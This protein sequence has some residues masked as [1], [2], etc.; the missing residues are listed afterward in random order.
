[1]QRVLVAIALGVA[2]TTPIPAAAQSSTLEFRVSG[3]ST[4]RSWTCTAQ[5]TVTLSAGGPAAP[6]LPNGIRVATIT[7]PVKSFTCPYDE[8]NDHLREAMKADD[9]P[10]I[11][12]RLDT[13]QVAGSRAQ[14][15]GTLTITDVSAP[16]SLPIALT[17]SGQGV[18]V[19]GDTRLDM[20]KFGVEPPVVLAGLLRVRP[21]IRIEFSGLIRP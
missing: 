18:Q 21:Q 14:A 3:T 20:T 9:F 7:V 12:Y 5:G 13:Y 11:T 8:M 15:T 4:V 1:M 10:D 6:G 2:M 16:V 19:E 17:P